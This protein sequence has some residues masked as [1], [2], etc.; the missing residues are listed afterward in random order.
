MKKLLFPVCLIG[1]FIL[2]I[3]IVYA[4]KPPVASTPP[5][6]PKAEKRKA[7]SAAFANFKVDSKDYTFQDTPNEIL[8]SNG[9]KIKI[10]KLNRF[11]IP[12]GVNV[13]IP[14]DISQRFAYELAE[15][16]I[17][18]TNTNSVEVKLGAGASETLFNNLK[19]FA[20]ET[21]AKAFVSQYP[22][23]FGSIYPMMEPAQTEKLTPIFKETTAMIS[24][25]YKPGQ[26]KSSRGII[27]CLAKAAKHIDKI[28]VNTQ[29][30]STNKYYGCPLV[31]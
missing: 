26:T 20:A 13:N 10:V 19:F 2:G 22:L 23:S 29:E 30:F 21:G 25:S 9:M 16:E 7:D 15:V 14:D 5:K 27:I 17:T 28:I 18:A 11:P 6:D 31:F 12:R 8:L 1:V 4:G 3:L 24:E